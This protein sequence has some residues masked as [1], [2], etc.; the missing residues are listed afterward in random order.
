MKITFK[1][2]SNSGIGMYAEDGTLMMLMGD[3]IHE[4]VFAEIEKRN[5]A[6]EQLVEALKSIIAKCPNPKLP[7]GM[8]VVKTAV[9]ALALAKKKGK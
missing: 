6:H 4:Q 1:K 8:S 9:A 3:S 7:Y 5:N 2:S